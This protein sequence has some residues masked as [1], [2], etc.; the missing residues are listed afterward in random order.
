[1]TSWRGFICGRNRQQD[2]RLL[3]RK[4]VDIF[5]GT[6]L[7]AYFAN[8]DRTLAAGDVAVEFVCA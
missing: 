8:V 6:E 3:T 4:V 7:E 5:A 1:M 2:Y